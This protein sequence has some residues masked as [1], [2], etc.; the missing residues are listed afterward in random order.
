MKQNI[1]NILK[2]ISKYKSLRG[3]EDTKVPLSNSDECRQ[4]FEN[5]RAEIL[6]HLKSDTNKVL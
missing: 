5:E 2:G 1:N 3:E 4:V 6:S